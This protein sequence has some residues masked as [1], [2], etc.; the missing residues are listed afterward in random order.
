[1]FLKFFA[2]IPKSAER[3]SYRSAGCPDAIFA[4]TGD[5]AEDQGGNDEG[6]Y[7]EY[8]I[9]T[10][11]AAGTYFWKVTVDDSKGGSIDSPTWSFT[12]E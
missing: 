2:G 5:A 10:P 4:V 8:K 12:V 7:R 6:P 3:T 11:I 1:L 9:P